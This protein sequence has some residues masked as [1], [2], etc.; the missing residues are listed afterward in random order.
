M[1]YSPG[2]NGDPPTE[3]WTHGSTAQSPRVFLSM[4]LGSPLFWNKKGR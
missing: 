2:M 4:S 1:F 3:K